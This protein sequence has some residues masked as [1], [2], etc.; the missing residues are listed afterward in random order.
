MAAI[1]PKRTRP[2]RKMKCTDDL[3]QSSDGHSEGD[4]KPKTE[5]EIEEAHLRIVERL[6]QRKLQ[7]LQ[8]KKMNK[9]E[10]MEKEEELQRQQN[11]KYIQLRKAAAQRRLKIICSNTII[12]FLNKGF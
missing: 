8:E 1:K 11:E 5:K 4:K 3:I 7:M 9:V 10:R 6:K 12:Y 2:P